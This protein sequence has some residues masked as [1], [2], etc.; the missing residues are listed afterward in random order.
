MKAWSTF[1]EG[2]SREVGRHLADL[3]APNGILCLRGELGAGKTT[4]TQGLA[5]GL[6][7][8]PS[9]V[10][11]PS[12]TIIREHEGNGGRLIHIDL[13]RLEPDQASALGLEEIL[14]G[15][16]VKAI[17][18]PERLPFEIPEAN[19]LKIEV[20]DDG[21]RRIEWLEGTEEKKTD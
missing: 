8:E 15:A 14:A 10:Q 21:S 19:H 4:L 6:G 13:Y 17:E 9:E 18:W 12:Y 16:G 3:L 7:I 2:E 1:S 20:L 11:S 5:S